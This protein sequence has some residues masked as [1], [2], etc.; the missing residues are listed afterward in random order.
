M[1]QSHL[2]LICGLVLVVVL[3]MSWCGR[4][5]GPEVAGTPTPAQ[6]PPQVSTASPSASAA[7][8]QVSAT[9][10]ATQPPS[11]EFRK[12]ADKVQPAIILVTVFDQFGQLVRTGTGFFISEDG[13]F[14][15]DGQVVEGA[16]H[17]VAKSP[18]G[19]IRNVTGFLASSTSRDLALLKAE[20][21]TGV[22]F[23]PLS[24]AAE[25]DTGTPVAIIRSSL[26]HRDQ[27]V[28][29]ATISARR[30]D[31]GGERLEISNPIP[32]EA[33]GSPVIDLNGNVVG[34]VTSSHEQGATTKVVRPATT[35][36]LLSAQI[37][38]G[39]T[40][41]WAVAESPT[42]SPSP[43]ARTDNNRKLK[44]IY[45]PAPKYPDEARFSASPIRGSG[46]FRVTFNANG[47]V[48]NVETVQSTG[49]P[50]LDQA[51]FNAL[52]QWKSEPGHEW[53]ILVPITFEP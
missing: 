18:D 26:A 40:G 14:V 49:R 46:R 25:L 1:K 17:A 27:L 13:Q 50:I 43:F 9:P 33:E 6:T 16:A 11:P 52:R 35:L 29:A 10:P 47:Q 21:K 7:A 37:K 34:V 24:K 4:K 32:N 45:N 51:A 12:V 5:P 39:A 3:A 38:P 42:P 44:V 19:K 41:R 8:A 48:K 20:T 36:D 53:A 23:L 15:T 30:S 22:P 28:I 31:Q 2:A